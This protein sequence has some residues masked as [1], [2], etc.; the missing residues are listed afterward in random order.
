MAVNIDSTCDFQNLWLPFTQMAE[1]IT[2]FTPKIV[3]GEGCWLIDDHGKRYLDAIA[4]WWVNIHG[5]DE[6]RLIDEIKKQADVLPHCSMGSMVHEPGLKLARML[7]RIAPTGLERV[8]YSDDGSTA[9]EAAIKISY[10]FFHQNGQAQRKYFVAMKGAYH[11]DTLGGVSLGDIGSYHSRFRDLCFPAL[12]AD[13]PDCATCDEGENL[14]D[15]PG[16]PEPTCSLKC[17]GPLED[18]LDEHGT[19]C[20]GLVTE[21]LVQGANGMRMYKSAALKRMRELCDNHGMHLILDCVAVAFG[22]TGRMFAAEHAGISPD[23]MAVAKGL[24]GGYMPL[25]ATLA[26]REIFEGFLG[27]YEEDRKL[28]HGHSFTGNPL[29]AACG[30]R[31]LELFEEDHI[32]ETLPA[33]VNLLHELWASMNDLDHTAGVRAMGMIAALDLEKDPARHVSYEPEEKAGKQVAAECLEQGVF[34]RPLGDTMYILPPLAIKPDEIELAVTTMR[35]AIKKI[36][37]QEG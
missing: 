17:L 34:V 15:L 5:H 18:L 13:A 11:G 16:G 20:C 28:A 21:P 23:L 12:R 22:R 7:A 37:G 4:S 31:N 27:K 35:K 10:Q 33:K 14:L 24:T 32:F 30:V 26:T 1:P 8:F 19:E 6:K 29:A 36:T 2:G 3:R 9:V 25:A